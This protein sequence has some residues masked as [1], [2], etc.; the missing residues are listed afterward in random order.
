M[1]VLFFKT[2]TDE[3]MYM[4][5]R[6]WVVLVTDFLLILILDILFIMETTT[7]ILTMNANQSS[8]K[9]QLQVIHFLAL[10]DKGRLLRNLIRT[11]CTQ[12]C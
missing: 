2:S 12:G 8:H 7:M 10:L 5:K 6:H 3:C 11:Q 9:I 4:C 1:H